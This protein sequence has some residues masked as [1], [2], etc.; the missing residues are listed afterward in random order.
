MQYR[1]IR[2]NRQF[3]GADIKV[4]RSVLFHVDNTFYRDCGA[5]PAAVE[6]VATHPNGETPQNGGRIIKPAFGQ[7]NATLSNWRQKI[8]DLSRGLPAAT[9]TQP[10]QMGPIG[11]CK[12]IHP[13]NNRHR[14]TT[15]GALQ[16]AAAAPSRRRKRRVQASPQRHRL[17]AAS[18]CRPSN[19]DQDQ[20]IVTI[21][22]PLRQPEHRANLARAR[23]TAQRYDQSPRRPS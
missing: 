11:G 7:Y 21:K 20:P 1:D 9:T 16:H 2:G 12:P 5:K 14:H 22:L 23:F 13:L 3:Y 18:P 19:V 6:V 8:I 10:P 4:N 17:P 15:A